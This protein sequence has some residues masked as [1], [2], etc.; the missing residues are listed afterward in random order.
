MQAFVFVRVSKQNKK[1]GK[2]EA[3][4]SITC[5][6]SPSSQDGQCSVFSS[7]QFYE[8]KKIVQESFNVKFL[9]RDFSTKKNFIFALNGLNFFS[10]GYR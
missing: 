8:L 9:E 1:L 7:Q 10:I 3:Y 5:E 2:I 6:T 4:L